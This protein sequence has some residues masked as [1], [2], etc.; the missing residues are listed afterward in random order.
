[1]QYFGGKSRISNELSDELNKM[2][3]KDQSFVDLFCGSCNVVSKICD[4]R[5]RIAN[6]KHPY[7]IKMHSEIQKG[8]IPPSNVTE[9]EYKHIK[10]NLDENQQLSGFV[11]FACSFSGKW[12]GGYARNKR[13][14]NFALQSK[15][16]LLAKHNTMRDVI[17]T[18]FD[19]NKVDIP[20]GSLVYCDIPYKDTTQ[21]SNILGIF[22]H[23]EFYNWIISNKENFTVVFSEYKKNVPSCFSIIWEKNSNKEIRNKND[24]REETIEVLAKL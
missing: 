6:D 21:Y 8:W 4:S 12:W 7:L 23:E 1:M 5:V 19:Y 3:K 22:D 15:R 2:L 20:H 17:F 9:E 13:G 11:G 24:I 18:S 10:N 16:S 14:D